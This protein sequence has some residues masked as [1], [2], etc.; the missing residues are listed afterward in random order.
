MGVMTMKAACRAAPMALSTCQAT[1]C[2][3]TAW[4]GRGGCGVHAQA[5]WPAAGEQAFVDALCTLLQ[6]D[7]RPWRLRRCNCPSC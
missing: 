1:P 6:T 5:A 3:S 7:C 2:S 4:F